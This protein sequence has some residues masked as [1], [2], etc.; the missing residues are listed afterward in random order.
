MV[1]KKKTNTK[2]VKGAEKKQ[3]SQII[4]KCVIMVWDVETNKK[5]NM[6]TS[7]NRFTSKANKIGL[8]HLTMWNN[9][10]K[11]KKRERKTPYSY[12]N[13][14]TLEKGW[15]DHYRHDGK[16]AKDAMHLQIVLMKNNIYW[17]VPHA[18]IHTILYLCI[19]YNM[20]FRNDTFKMNLAANN[21]L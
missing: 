21:V 11:K 3:P 16:L 15:E 12:L 10:M 19:K 18:S 13:S 8:N 9:N 6:K 1:Q 5:Q 17:I 4:V 7:E 14:S 2:K 20:L